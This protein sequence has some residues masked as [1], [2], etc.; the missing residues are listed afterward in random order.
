MLTLFSQLLFLCYCFLGLAGQTVSADIITGFLLTVIS[1]SLSFSFPDGRYTPF[2]FYAFAAAAFFYPALYFC[3]PMLFYE[4][5][6][7]KPI[8]CMI[9]FGAGAFYHYGKTELPYFLFLCLG[10]I[11]ALFLQ[12]LISRY[13]LLAARHRKIRDDSTELN[14][15]LEE[16]NRSLLEK[17]D[18]E[19]HNATLQERNRIAREIH[20]NVGHLLSR[21]IL[22]NGAIQTIN[23][24]SQCSESLQLLQDTLSHAMDNIRSSVHNLHD[25]SINLRKSMEALIRDFT[26][27]TVHLEYDIATDIPANIRYAFISITKEA[28]TNISKHSSAS[29]VEIIIREHPAMLQL[30]IHDNGQISAPK[31]FSFS[32]RT[33]ENAGIGLINMYDRVKL[34]GGMFQINQ[35]N[36]FQI[37]ISIPK[38][39]N[40][41]GG[42]NSE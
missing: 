16:R 22:L 26:F 30:I 7:R 42:Q 1:V 29:S 23:Q 36:G 2:L 40:R 14:L 27:C 3:L 9:L 32:E 31:D 11:L 28:L 12:Y 4:I 38:K 8:P 13:E 18:Y 20:D 17:Q 34:L 25:D 5:G 33:Y 6:R 24:D 19:I 10:C 35:D 37:F 41:N 39:N 21:C 15:L